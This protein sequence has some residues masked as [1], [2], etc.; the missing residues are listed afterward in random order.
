MELTHFD[1]NGKAVMVDVSAVS[2]THLCV[3]NSDRVGRC[4]WYRFHSEHREGRP[5]R[6]DD[7]VSYTHLNNLQ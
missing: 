6:S 2:Y 4:K 7:P 1:E 5:D 3:C